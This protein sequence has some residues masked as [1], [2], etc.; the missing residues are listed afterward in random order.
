MEMI[1]IPEVS[2]GAI[3]P[4][5]TL[6]VTASLLL[7][8]EVFGN[9]KSRDSLGY[10]A[11][12]GVLAAFGFAY[13]MTGEPWIAFSGLYSVDNFSTFFKLIFLL[14][15]GLTIL[16]SKKY[17]DSDKIDNGEY[18]ALLLFATCGMLVMASGADLIT[19]F[20]G[21]ELMSISL[22]VLAGFTR[23]RL[24]SNEASMKY[25]ILGSLSTGIMLYGMALVYG[26]TGSTTLYEIGTAVSAGGPNG[27]L[28]TVGV[29]LLLV[30]FA[31][32]VAA[33]PFHMW[34][35][36]VYQGAPA[37]VTAFMS[38]GP[39]AAGFAALL[40]VMAEGFP[41]MKDDWWAIIWI[42]AVATMTMGNLM[43]LVQDNVKRM[44]AY[45]SIAHAGYL[46][47]GLVAASEMGVSAILFYMLAYTF[48]NIGAFAIVAIVAKKDERRLG[49]A[50]YTGMGYSHPLL[51]VS[52][53]VFLFSL[54]GLPPTAGFVGKFYIFM[55]A[56]D[57]GYVWLAVI[58]VVNS[59]VSVF[60]YLR[61]T[62]VMYMKEA[63]PT[64]VPSAPLTFA[65][66][67]IVAL[68][69]SVLGTLWLGLM[70]GDYIT[71]ARSAFLVF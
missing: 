12:G 62:V 44:L 36:D 51:A 58:G 16:I 19:I 48:M 64:A 26:V 32:K 40:R 50:D 18:Y 61:L 67:V 39:K 59:V 1:Q 70:P 33:V 30:G 10:I 57:G 65:T 60:Y 35:P 46:L 43:A 31:F 4:E 45:S 41:A 11:L 68:V 17:S 8:L 28:L 42:L 47:V 20:M 66:P 5:I 27:S 24:V 7:L 13:N 25:F 14:A 38:V 15:T 52:L 56:L 23:D 9:D 22:Y 21:L 29:V 53:A 3:G 69:V 63:E 34:T 55:S 54:A 71:F 37:P 6:V 2:F 49:F